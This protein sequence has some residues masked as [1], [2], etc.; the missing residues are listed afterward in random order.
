[1]KKL[2]ILLFSQLLFGQSEI[3]LKVGEIGGIKSI[4]NI[5]SNDKDLKSLNSSLALLNP[6]FNFILLQKKEKYLR[7]ILINKF[8][9]RQLNKND[10]RYLPS[11]QYFYIIATKKLICLRYDNSEHMILEKRN[12]K[13]YFIFSSYY[14]YIDSL[15][16]FDMKLKPMVSVKY[17]GSLIIPNIT[18]SKNLPFCSYNYTNNKYFAFNLDSED[19]N[20]EFKNIDIGN[21]EHKLNKLIYFEDKNNN[22]NYSK[23]KSILNTR[24]FEQ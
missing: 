2:L 21:I 10:S 4:V 3:L 15:T 7:L 12:K 8:D 19:I 14:N 23:L 1:M 9:I 22:Y 18:Y 5:H 24:S 20:N 16:L 13:I 11:E 17:S 6:N